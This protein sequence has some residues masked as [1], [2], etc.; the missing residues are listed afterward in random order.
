MKILIIEDN[1]PQSRLIKKLLDKLKTIESILA[2]DA[3]EG[4]AMLKVIPD[5]EMIILDQNMPFVSGME[6]LKKIQS[7]P[8][9]RDIPVLISTAEENTEE[10]LKAGAA[11]C[12]KKPYDLAEF[13]TFILEV[14][15]LLE[16]ERS[17]Y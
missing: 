14:Q 6:L 1:L 16:L 13:S 4:Y 3:F 10:F 11:K 15:Q 7:V 5:I 12:L 8:Q 2:P 9:F 17:Q